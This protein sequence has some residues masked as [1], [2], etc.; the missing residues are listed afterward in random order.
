MRERWRFLSRE[1]ADAC[2]ETGLGTSSADPQSVIEGSRQA[3]A[4]CS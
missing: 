3:E 2:G 1:S 4:A